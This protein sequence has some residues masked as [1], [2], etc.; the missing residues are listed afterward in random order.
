MAIY[1]WIFLTVGAIPILLLTPSD[2]NTTLVIRSVYIMLNFMVTAALLVF[3]KLL[4]IYHDRNKEMRKSLMSETGNHPPCNRF[5]ASPRL[6][7][8]PGDGPRA[9]TRIIS[10]L[11]LCPVIPWHSIGCQPL[12]KSSSAE[13]GG[14]VPMRSSMFTSSGGALLDVPS[15]GSSILRRTPTLSSQSRILSPKPGSSIEG[16]ELRRGHS[17]PIGRNGTPATA[18]AGQIISDCVELCSVDFSESVLGEAPIEGGKGK[19]KMEVARDYATKGTI[20]VSEVN[21][22]TDLGQSSTE[23]SDK[24]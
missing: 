21:S 17:L 13:I 14:S 15:R 4:L 10:L 16:T 11:T 3:Y 9:R 5:K 19:K 23:T 22:S 6:R 7:D 12:S 18:V 2:N 24:L 8:T 20:S 1:N